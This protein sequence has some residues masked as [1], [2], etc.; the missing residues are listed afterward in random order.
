LRCLEGRTW[1]LSL[2]RG[3]G[4][5]TRQ[6]ASQPPAHRQEQPATNRNLN[7]SWEEDEKLKTWNGRRVGQLGWAGGG[8]WWAW[9][10]VCQGP[11]G[12]PCGSAPGEERNDGAADARKTMAKRVIDELLLLL[13]DGVVLERFDYCLAIRLDASIDMIV[14]CLGMRLAWY[15]ATAVGAG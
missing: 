2:N 11:P 15:T 3:A 8:P 4:D 14:A 6:A 13:K 5:S 10:R 12:T 9:L 7:R 1:R